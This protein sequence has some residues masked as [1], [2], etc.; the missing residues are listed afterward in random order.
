M[1]DRRRGAE[2][3]AA[4]PRSRAIIALEPILGAIERA[5]G[6]SRLVRRDPELYWFAVF[7]E[8]AGGRHHGRGASAATTSP[9][10]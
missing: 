8:P 5:A 6:R 9:S 7:G 3:A 10:S 2:R 4:P 1:R